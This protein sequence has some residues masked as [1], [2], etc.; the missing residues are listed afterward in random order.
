MRLK[1]TLRFLVVLFVAFIVLEVGTRIILALNGRGFFRDRRFRSPWFTVYDAPAPLE[2]GDFLYFKRGQKTTRIT[3][4]DTIRIICLGGSTTVNAANKNHYPQVLQ[5]KLNNIYK[6]VKFEVLNA[7][8]DAFSSEHSFVNLSLRLL[9]YRPDCIIVYHNINDLSANYFPPSIKTD[10][11]NKY[12]NN[13]FL[14]PECKIGMLRYL[15]NSRLISYFL[16]RLNNL[17]F[18][19]HAAKLHNPEVSKGGEIFRNNLINILEVAKAHDIKVIFG[20]QAACFKKGEE[21]IYIKK[22]DFLEYNNIVRQVAREYNADLVDCFKSLAE[23]E[24][25]FSDLVHYTASGIEKVSDAFLSEIR[26]I[27]P[28][29]PKNLR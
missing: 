3:P 18:E 24:G 17:A 1:K 20:V 26:K 6:H 9:Y 12:V 2:N 22:E 19:R 29:S 14:A 11:A 27:Y 8:G 21:Y 23:K 10:Y 16:M 15:Y 28:D 5:D 25:Y 13:L 7:G 4:A